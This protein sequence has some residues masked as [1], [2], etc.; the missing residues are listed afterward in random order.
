ML[1]DE[2]RAPMPRV[3]ATTSHEI[4]WLGARHAD[5]C[6]HNWPELSAQVGVSAAAVCFRSASLTRAAAAAERMVW[7]SI[8]GTFFSRRPSSLLPSSTDDV[9]PLDLQVRSTRRMRDKLALS[10]LVVVLA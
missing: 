8:K 4:C 6:N 1:Q 5:R 10:L 3:Q 7:A 2:A 9:I